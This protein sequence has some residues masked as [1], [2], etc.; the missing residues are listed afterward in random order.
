MMILE[1]FKITIKYWLCAFIFY[2]TV[3]PKETISISYIEAT[4]NNINAASAKESN[5]ATHNNINA[6]STK[7]PNVAT[8][9]NINAASTKEPNV[10]TN[11][12]INAASTKESNETSNKTM[13]ASL[14]NEN[15]KNTAKI[16]ATV[17]DETNKINE[18]FKTN[19]K[20][21]IKEASIDNLKDATS[22]ESSVASID[23]DVE[24]NK[25]FT[26]FISINSLNNKFKPLESFDENSGLIS[27]SRSKF[28][29]SHH[30]SGEPRT[31]WTDGDTSNSIQDISGKP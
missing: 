13:D 2:S 9:N 22:S 11:N 26:N 1:F 21:A 25:N 12:N 31:L 15:N 3:T 6:A 4:H 14:N 17:K 18:D 5:E 19:P 24:T 16:N 8:N 7:E 10:A 23:T 27:S 30:S 29:I 28:N 20:E